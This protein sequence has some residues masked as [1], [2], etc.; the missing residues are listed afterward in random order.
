[1]DKMGLRD[2]TIYDFIRRNAQ[3]YPDKDCMVFKGARLS[4]REFKDRC[5]RLAA[6]LIKAGISK[7]DGLGIVA[8][9]C[10]E[11]MV[12][13]GAA[14][15]IGAILLPVN[16]RFQAEEVEF[17]LNDCT[18]RFVF[19]GPDFRPRV[20][21]LAPRVKSIESWYTIGGGEAA[22]GFRPF[23]ELYSEK[24]SRD[25]IDLPADSGFVIIHTAA[26]DGRPRGGAFEPRECLLCQ[27]VDDA[28]VR[29][30]R[31]RLSY[32]HPSP[33]SHRRAGHDHGR[34]ARG[35]EECHR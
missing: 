27:S 15:K 34:N 9:N 12:L 33:F 25:E 23:A 32:L 5:D 30:E 2:T 31:Q 1:L 16:W 29:D 26:V 18:P 21:Q 11:F 17:V 20:S 22:D 28:P 35:R 7:G 10:D 13:Y 14:A 6:G 24:G 8:Y 19:A 3:V 4:H